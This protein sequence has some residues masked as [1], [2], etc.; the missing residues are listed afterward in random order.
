[1]GSVYLHVA[2]AVASCSGHRVGYDKIAATG[3]FLGQAGCGE[4]RQ[5][6]AWPS[7]H[8]ETVDR[9]RSTLAVLAERVVL[10]VSRRRRLDASDD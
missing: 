7:P 9:W 10:A 4:D 1:M 3:V 5:W 2:L 8:A 6:A